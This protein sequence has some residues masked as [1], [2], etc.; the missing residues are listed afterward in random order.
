MAWAAGTH[1]SQLLTVSIQHQAVPGRKIWRSGGPCDTLL[2]LS[3]I[4]ILLFPDATSRDSATNRQDQWHLFG[5]PCS[6]LAHALRNMLT[7]VEN[8]AVCV[9]CVCCVPA[10]LSSCLS[11]REY[12][13]SR[14]SLAVLGG[15]PLRQLEAWVRELFEAVPAAR[16]Q[17]PPSFSSQGM[18]FE[19]SGRAGMLCTCCCGPGMQACRVPGQAVHSWSHC[20]WGPA[21]LS[22]QESARQLHNLITVSGVSQAF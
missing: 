22:G 6:A 17:P 5:T 8:R 14:M 3:C 11:S 21:Q 12:C 7:M 20:A 2:E 4:V 15:Q 10:A 1:T 16:Q 18:P 19:V 9:V 13:P